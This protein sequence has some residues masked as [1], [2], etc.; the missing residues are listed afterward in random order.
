MKMKPVGKNQRVFFELL[1]LNEERF[2][3]ITPF[4]EYKSLFQMYECFSK[5]VNRTDRQER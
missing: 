4:T 5:K 2:E 3:V 1:M